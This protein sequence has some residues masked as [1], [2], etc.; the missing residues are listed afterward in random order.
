MSGGWDAAVVMLG[1][2]YDGDPVTF[3]TELD[4]LLDELGEIP[5]VLMTVTRFR[6]IQDQVNYVIHST[7]GRRRNVR[8]LD[9]EAR[10]AGEGGN[11]LLSDDGVHLS[12]QR[13]VSCWPA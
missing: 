4:A 1:N 13:S 3:G 11:G 5:V 6:P 2:N 12:D 8:L 9:W 7:A 10:T